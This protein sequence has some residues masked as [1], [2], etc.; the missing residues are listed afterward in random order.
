MSW[1]KSDEDEYYLVASRYEDC[2]KTLREAADGAEEYL[3]ILC[4]IIER[5]IDG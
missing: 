2:L 1:S 4:D 3:K 5:N